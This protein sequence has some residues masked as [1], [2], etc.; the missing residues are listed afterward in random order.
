M[1][2]MKKHF[3]QSNIFSFIGLLLVSSLIPL[4]ALA[5]DRDFYSS[6]DIIF[7]EPESSITVNGSGSSSGTSNSNTSGN[8][9][10]TGT[11]GTAPQTGSLRAFV[12]AY[13][14][15]AFEVGKKYSIPYE[16]ILA[17]G[18][19]ESSY[20]RSGLTT[21]ANN[22][23]GIKA[24]SNWTGERITLP[25][26]EYVNGEKYTKVASF[27]KYSTPEA[28]WDDYGKFITSNSRYSSALEY[29]DDPIAYITAIWEAGYATD[30]EYVNNVGSIANTIIDY[31]AETNKWPSSSEMGS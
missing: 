5:Y 22:F 31:I 3:I 16:A 15:M 7:Y 14:Q 2:N 1:L 29:P 19:L 26:S 28:G 20:G 9:S 24:D 27:R 17:Q 4:R 13:G 30:P 25:T 23:F 11:I 21:K 12:D 6:N 18:I 10:N 8:T